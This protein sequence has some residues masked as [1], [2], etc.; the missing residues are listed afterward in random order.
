M[1]R[2]NIGV[3]PAELSNKHLI[4]EHR[5]IK[6]IPNCIKKGRYSLEG[7]PDHFKLGSGHVKFFYDKLSFLQRR[8]K[9]LYSECILRG[10][11]VT[12]FSDAFDDLPAELMGDYVPTAQDRA[13]ILQRIKERS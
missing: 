7:Q 2:I 3:K 6:R 1:T 9:A 5:E 8:Y 10:F 11:N 13:L 4:A 12:D